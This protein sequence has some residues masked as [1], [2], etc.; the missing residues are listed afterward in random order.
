M[1]TMNYFGCVAL[2]LFAVSALMADDQSPGI[3]HSPLNPMDQTPTA[4]SKPEPAPDASQTY[5]GRGL[6]GTAQ[7]HETPLRR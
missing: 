2:S 4:M 5:R 6:A 3:R 7:D 1:K